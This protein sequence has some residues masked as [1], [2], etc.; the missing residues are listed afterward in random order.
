MFKSNAA[1]SRSTGDD[2]HRRRTPAWIGFLLLIATMLAGCSLLRDR[3]GM[4]PPQQ[5]TETVMLVPDGITPTAAGPS[6]TP[7]LPTSTLTASPTPSMTPTPRPTATVAPRSTPETIRAKI[8]VVWP[9]GEASVRDADL[10]NITAYL[11]SDTGNDAPPCDWEPTVRLWAAQ[12]S[13]PARPIAVGEKRMIATGGRRFPAWDFNDVD[14]SAAREP[15]NKLTFFVTVDGVKTLHNVWVHASDARTIF[16]QPD[17]PTGVVMRRPAA[18]DANIEVVW[19]HDSL[20]VEEATLA[21]ITG[22][23]FESD[24]KQAIPPDLKWS[25]TLRLHQTN[26][27]DTET[28]EAYRSAPIG[29]SRVITSENGV[30]FL[31]WDFDNIDV[32]A[33]Q[34][35]LNKIYF[36]LSGDDVT[37]FP[38]VWAHGANTPTIFP[39]T[40]ILNSCK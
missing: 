19:P 16:P 8:E 32:S 17:T 24:T 27:A 39:Q 28:A 20:P 23:L 29:I 12:N 25:P 37:T 15:A 7:P 14:V 1:R 38:N 30:R 22:Y 26:N 13:Q 18:V 5:P 2:R 40:D 9:H 6:S 3:T 34:D 36:W 4:E 11:I 33:A 21:N 31:A 35:S 10:A